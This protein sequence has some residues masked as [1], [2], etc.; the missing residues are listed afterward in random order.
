MGARG[1]LARRARPYGA[2]QA[3]TAHALVAAH[4]RRAVRGGGRQA[5]VA[6]A[7]QFRFAVTETCRPGGAVYQGAAFSLPL[8]VAGARQAAEVPL[9]IGRLV[10]HQEIVGKAEKP[11]PEFSPW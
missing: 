6:A 10:H 9:D 3:A 2:R 1:G 8:G 5:G 11:R 4:R 7:T